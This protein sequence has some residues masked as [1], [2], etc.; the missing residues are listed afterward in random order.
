MGPSTAFSL[1]SGASG[2]R[3]LQGRYADLD[4]LASTLAVLSRPAGITDRHKEA[5]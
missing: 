2:G 5:S 3:H 1:P 4:G